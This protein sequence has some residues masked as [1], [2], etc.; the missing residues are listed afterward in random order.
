M[1]FPKP[2]I[3]K[4]RHENKSRRYSRVEEEG[5]DDDIGDGHGMTYTIWIELD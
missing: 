5:D 1:L 3:L 4:A 2:F